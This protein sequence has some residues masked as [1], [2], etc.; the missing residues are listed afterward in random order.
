MPNSSDKRFA[1]AL[2]EEIKALQGAGR[3]R[4]FKAGE[5][6]FSA[7]GAGGGFY[8]VEKG[9]GEVSALV[10]TEESR[11]LATIGPADFFGEM[12]VLDDAPRSATA[13]AGVATRATFLSRDELLGLLEKKP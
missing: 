3:T 2:Q 8:V 10:A 7:G 5:V 9:E 13:R 12:A 11:L 1:G 4:E 6:I